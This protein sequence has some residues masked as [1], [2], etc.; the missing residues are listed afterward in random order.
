M[1]VVA[2]R[3]VVFDMDGVLVDSGAHHRDAWVAM[4][5]DCGVTPPP[6]FWRLTIGR[7]AEE[8][9]ALL[10]GD[11]GRGEARRLAELKREHYARLARRGLVAVAGAGA[12]V[13]ALVRARV[14][15][16]VATSAS[17][18]DLER[19]LDALGLSRHLDVTVTADDVRWGKPHPEIYLKA[20][21]ELGIDAAACVVFEDAIVGVQAA[22]AAGMRVIGVT[23]AHTTDELIGAGAE[24]AV[25]HFEAM[26]PLV[27]FLDTTPP[28]RGRVAVP[29]CG[30]GHDAR[31]LAAHGYEVTAFDFVPSVLDVA[32]RLA[33]REHVTV[34]F[35]QRDVF[36]LG[37]DLPHAFDGIW[38][39]TC[40]CAI[41]PARR[42]E[43]VRALAGTLRAGG[44]LLA[45]F[46][47]LRAQSAGPPFV[48]SPDEVRRLLAPAFR[49][50]RAFAPLRSARGRQGREW[51]ILARR[52]GA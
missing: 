5:R 51:M 32:R 4:C 21:E 50:E 47:P 7:P 8:A 34:S 6:E 25:P 14:P 16:A 48:V 46:F 12:F 2:P 19:V 24:R 31:L 15:R 49:I 22:R 23:T 20:A 10:V 37:R 11:I 45:C 29:G 18:R 36:T 28:P 27:D 44:W 35:E 9:V 40:Y 39:Y 52:T 33:A 43:Y 30:R 38:E 3:A 13:Q 1:S 42:A 17:R 41:D 26:Q